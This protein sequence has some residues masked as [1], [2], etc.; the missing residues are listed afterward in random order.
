MVNPDPA[1]VLPS[2]CIRLEVLDQT[3]TNHRPIP[4]RADCKQRVV[5]DNTVAV[6][7]NVRDAYVIDPACYLLTGLTV[8]IEVMIA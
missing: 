5:D 1:H 4:P 8:G 2:A 7:C 6:T 3:F